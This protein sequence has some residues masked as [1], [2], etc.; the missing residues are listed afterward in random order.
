VIL[1]LGIDGG[2]TKTSC[3]IA[4]E[5]N[6]LGTGFAG[7]S[8]IVRVGEDA[9]RASLSAAIRQACAAANADPST[10]RHSCIGAAGAARPETRDAI[11]RILA[12]LIGGDFE[13]VG[14]TA[15]ALEAAFGEGPGIIVIAGTG[16]IA[17]G[18][19]AKGQTFRAGGWGF[20]I[21]DE[22]SGHWIGRTAV[23]AALR[24]RDEADTPTLLESAC[25][26]FGVT[27]D[28][29]LILKV[30]ASPDFAALVPAVLAAADAG[31]I[32]A[33]RVLSYAGDELARLAK[34]AIARLFSTGEKVPV[35]MVGGVFRNSAMVRQVFYYSVRAG[36]PAAEI[37]TTVVEPV[38]GA[39]A[40]ARR[41]L[42]T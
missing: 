37:Q 4:D 31:D 27:N 29:Q 1:F 16:S 8:N 14:D 18:R 7:G 13:I 41:R 40:L 23:S 36:Y 24:A 17:Y 3:L 28:E 30:N 19:N 38:Q 20:A 12:D 25:K 5:N 15:I 32:L 6:V 26:I 21:S 42:K 39:L 9:A 34:L 11:Q 33:T 2:G 22:G 10:I 35:A